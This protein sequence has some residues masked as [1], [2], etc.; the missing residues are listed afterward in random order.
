MAIP[1]LDVAPAVPSVSGAAGAA[2]LNGTWSIPES[3]YVF[4]SST[5]RLL[6]KT[7]PRLEAHV[8][9]LHLRMKEP[10]TVEAV[11]EEVGKSLGFWPP[12][13]TDDPCPGINRLADHYRS[14]PDTSGNGLMER[15]FDLESRCKRLSPAS[16]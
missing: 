1:E 11:L 3:G 8:E 14:H 4:Q 16:T 7:A 10:I 6:G 2:A 9:R 13:Y 5:D 15:A 12:G